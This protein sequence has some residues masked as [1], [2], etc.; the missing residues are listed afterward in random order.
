M[1]HNT[2]RPEFTVEVN[3][4]MDRSM[5]FS[6][7]KETL[8]FREIRNQTKDFPYYVCDYTKEETT[9][10]EVERKYFKRRRADSFHETPF[11]ER[12][13]KTLGEL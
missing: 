13:I 3:D 9:Y 7:T 5:Y 1:K 2:K 10:E 6:E 4:R 12:P 8:T 11:S